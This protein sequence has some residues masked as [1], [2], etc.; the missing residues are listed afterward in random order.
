MKTTVDKLSD[1]R[2]KLTV[3]VPFAEL[4]QEID[5]AYA[6]IAQQDSIQVSVRARH[7][8]SLLTLAS[9]AAPS[10]SRLS[11]TCCLPVTSRQSRKTI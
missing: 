4:D 6:A 11:M 8:A 10:W 1:T 9:A 5:Q 3:N 2:V 7:R